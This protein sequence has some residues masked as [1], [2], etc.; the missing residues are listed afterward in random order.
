MHTWKSFTC[1][2]LADRFI[3]SDLL[4][5]ISI[6]IGKVALAWGMNLHGDSFKT[7]K[8]QTC[9][10]STPSFTFF[11]TFSLNLKKL[12]MESLIQILLN[13]YVVWHDNKHNFIKVKYFQFCP[14]LGQHCHFDAPFPKRM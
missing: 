11:K 7:E 14:P 9:K 5:Q 3:H 2:H 13:D 6:L 4:V 12:T 8:S 10:M 1:G